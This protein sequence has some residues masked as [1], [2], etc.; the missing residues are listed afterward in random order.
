MF[1]VGAIDAYFS[2]AYA[3]IVAATVQRRHDCIH[4]CDRP[5]I[6]PQKLER[7]G[8]V[9]RVVHD[10]VFLVERCDDHITKEF[11]E[12]LLSCNASTSTIA[13]VGY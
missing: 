5:R 1:A 6:A 13:R 2:D 9:E 10:A 7:A 8:T 4:N 11:R 12:F 3:D